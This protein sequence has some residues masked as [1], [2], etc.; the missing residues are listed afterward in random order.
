MT[1]TTNRMCRC[2]ASVYCRGL[3][4]ADVTPPVTQ[5]ANHPQV[6]PTATAAR[7]KVAKVS[8][9]PDEATG[10]SL[11]HRTER[12]FVDSF[13]A[14]LRFSD[15]WPTLRFV[16]EFNFDRGRPDVIAV[17]ESGVLFAFEAKLTRWRDALHQAHRNRCFA[18]A[19]YV[20][21]PEATARLAA[22]YEAEFRRRKVGLCYPDKGIL[23]QL[24]DAP[25]LEPWQPWL[26]E[27]AASAIEQAHGDAV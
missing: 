13:L 9:T 23:V 25:P 20:V 18:N 21:V 8:R 2:E 12:E 6:K 27:R 26:H 3:E 1:A 5:H 7:A 11:R 22:R 16:I 17:D 10:A 4:R 24:I 15:E 19:T 14:D